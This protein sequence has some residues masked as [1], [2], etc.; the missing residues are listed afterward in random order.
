M[1]VGAHTVTH[2]D[3]AI[4]SIAEQWHQVTGSVRTIGEHLGSPIVT[5][6][7]PSG[8]HNPDTVKIVEAAG[9]AYA[10][11]TDSG[12]AT[13]ADNPE[14]LPRYRVTETTDFSALLP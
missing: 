13:S 1:E 9:I 2:P 12:V 6:A 8:K 3:L 11:T 4:S 7:Y 5:F 10:V 14:L